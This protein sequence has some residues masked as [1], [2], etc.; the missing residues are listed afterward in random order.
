M[1]IAGMQLA[2]PNKI[3]RTELMEWVSQVGRKIET[4]YEQAG[5]FDL[6]VLPEL[7]FHPYTREHFAQLEHFAQEKTGMMFEQMARTAKHL[8]CAI[9]Y[10]YAEREGEAYYISQA[11]VS[12][13]GKLLANYRKLHIA[14]FGGSMEKEYFKRGNKAVTFT[15]DSWRFGLL[16][17]YDIRFPQLAQTLVDSGADVILHPVA[18]SKDPTYPSWHSFVQTRAI[19]NQVY[20]LS[21]NRAGTEFGQSIF[22]PAWHDS[23]HSPSIYSESEQSNVFTLEREHLEKVRNTYQFK[24]D[25]LTNYQQL[26]H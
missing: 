4:A 21:V 24:Q 23:E 18:F 7:S 8:Q 19:E 10:G 13:E 14:Q 20:L 22:S 6:V 11:V 12:K 3:S 16:I 5:G 15:I 26:L 9:C 2:V 17:C 1:K 25:R